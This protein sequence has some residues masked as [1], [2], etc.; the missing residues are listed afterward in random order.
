[1]T[2]SKRKMIGHNEDPALTWMRDMIE[3]GTWPDLMTTHDVNAA[4][5]N[6]VKSGSAGFSFVRSPHKWARYLRDLGG[7]KVYG[8]SQVR[9]KSGVKTRLWAT[10]GPERFKH[11]GEPQLAQAY[12]S[13]AGHA[14]AAEGDENVV[15]MT[16]E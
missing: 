3:G 16:Q 12:V 9:L 6:A 13:A 5:A 1:M 10:R 4:F 7:E 15:S 11:L 14:F 8:G 2:A